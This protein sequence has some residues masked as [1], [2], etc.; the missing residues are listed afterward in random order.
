MFTAGGLPPL[1]DTPDAVYEKLFGKQQPSTLMIQI[2]DTTENETGKVRE[3]NETYYRKYP[4][5][6]QRVKDVA[7]YLQNENISLPSGGKFSV[8]R[9]RQLGFSF[10]FHG[11]YPVLLLT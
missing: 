4:E 1:V 7:R 9:L 3:R 2:I 5:D 8:L 10:G 11:H 6:V